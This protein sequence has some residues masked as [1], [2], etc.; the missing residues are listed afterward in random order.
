M[1]CPFSNVRS[2]CVREHNHSCG[3]FGITTR[4]NS[5]SRKKMFLRDDKRY[6]VAMIGVRVDDMYLVLDWMG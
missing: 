5:V 1:S 3:G 2:I 4:L 6:V